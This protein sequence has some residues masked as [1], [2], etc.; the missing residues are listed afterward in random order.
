VAPDE[1]HRSRDRRKT[2]DEERETRER[3]LCR[4]RWEERRRLGGAKAVQLKETA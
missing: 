1:A 4:H 3:P 2:E